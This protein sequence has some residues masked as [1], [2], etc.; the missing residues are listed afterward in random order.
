M[1]PGRLFTLLLGLS[2]ASLCGLTF[3]AWGQVTQ[4]NPRLRSIPVPN[5]ALASDSTNPATP[6]DQSA[7]HAWVSVFSSLVAAEDWTK[8]ESIATLA[9]AFVASPELRTPGF[10]QAWQAWLK[11]KARRAWLVDDDRLGLW[12]LGRWVGDDGQPAHAP[13]SSVR[14][15]LA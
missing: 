9:P 1:T 12:R 4:P 15:Q 7:V 8:V 13:G 10:Q 6:D 2:L 5:Q 11:A 14:P 3:S